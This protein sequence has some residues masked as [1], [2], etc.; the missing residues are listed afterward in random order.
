MTALR[1]SLLEP[2]G[3]SNLLAIAT[4][5]RSWLHRYVNKHARLSSMFKEASLLSQIS[6][7]AYWTKQKGNNSESLKEINT[8]K[9]S[10]SKLRNAEFGAVAASLCLVQL[11]PVIALGF[12]KNKTAKYIVIAILISV[13]SIMNALFANTAKASNFGAVAA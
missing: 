9:Y 12:T 1:G 4:S 3:T 13:V 10:E 2:T 6:L 7:T 8:K 11:L 5:P